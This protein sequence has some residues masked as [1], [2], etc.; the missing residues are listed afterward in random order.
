MFCMF[1]CPNKVNK[2]FQQNTKTLS[3][4]LAFIIIITLLNTEALKMEFSVCLGLV[5]YRHPR[6][7]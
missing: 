3:G 7:F 6:H 4:I 1:W 5:L 2:H